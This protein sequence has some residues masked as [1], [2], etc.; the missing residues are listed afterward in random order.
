M[1][2]PQKKRPDAAYVNYL[3]TSFK[4][5][6]TIGAGVFGGIQLDKLIGWKFPLCTILLSLLSVAMAIYVLVRDTGKK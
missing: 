4:M 1:S 5:G 6:V 3:T 2:S